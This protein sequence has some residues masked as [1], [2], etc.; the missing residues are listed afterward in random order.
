LVVKKVFKAK[1]YIDVVPV[2]QPVE[3]GRRMQIL[4][5]GYRDDIQE[6]QDVM[7]D[8]SVVTAKHT[9][10]L[11]RV[12]QQRIAAHH[13]SE[14]RIPFYDP[15]TQQY[16]PLIVRN[17]IRNIDPEIQLWNSDIYLQTDVTQGNRV[18]ERQYDL[19][20]DHKRHLPD[21]LHYLRS[22]EHLATSGDMRIES[23]R[24]DTER[25]WH[26]NVHMLTHAEQDD[27]TNAH[28]GSMYLNLQE[29]QLNSIGELVASWK[30]NTGVRQVNRV[31]PQED[32]RVNENLKHQYI[33]VIEGMNGTTVNFHRTNLQKTFTTV[34]KDRIVSR[35]YT[36]TETLQQDIQ[37]IV[38]SIEQHN[39]TSKTP[40]EVLILIDAHGLTTRSNTSKYRENIPEP[41][42]DYQG[43]REGIIYLNNGF[44]MH[45]KDLQDILNPLAKIAKV[46]VIN[47]SC[48]S[49]AWLG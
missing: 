16:N 8:N 3:T 40:A 34:P 47:G 12:L 27:I 15:Q 29:N 31:F 38:R 2:I 43:G 37:K 13:A 28:W 24:T 30:S 39:A 26:P 45:E 18:I 32:F 36:D 10:I 48:H 42:Q 11:Y 6:L 17:Y 1:E 35:A 33:L 7:S 23:V 25:K 14:A 46:Y 19:P 41:L 44:K 21:V 5:R 9:Q 49:G 22:A 4:S 20:L